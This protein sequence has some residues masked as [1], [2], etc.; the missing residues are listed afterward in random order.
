MSEERFVRERI[1]GWT[2]LRALVTRAQQRGLRSLSG[3]DVRRLGALYRAATADLATARTLR[4]DPDTIA[5]VNRVAAAAHDLVYAAPARPAGSRLWHFVSAGF[6]ALVRR[7]AAYHVTAGVTFLLGVAAAFAVFRH[8][9]AF[10]D[11]VFGPDLRARAVASASG[12]SYLELPGMVRPVFSWGI[13]TNN[14]NAMLAAFALATPFAFGG[15]VMMLYQGMFALG[16]VL[17]V[18][19]DEGAAGSV[20]TFAAA[21]GPLELTAIFIGC[22]AGMRIGVAP[23]L[24]GRRERLAA[25]V[26]TAKESIALVGGAALMLLLAAQFEGHVSPTTLPPVVKW[27]VGAV[28]V[29]LL[30][31]Y[32]GRAGRRT[33]ASS[34]AAPNR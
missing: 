18:F 1:E 19:A 7:T 8:D 10:A 3:A 9:P 33:A 25:F 13:V 6:P 22:G 34:D 28:W 12:A 4:L 16:G 23:L 31:L 11:T 17:A 14:V 29:V 26:D 27:S 24:P 32:F 15:V 30:A 20:L 21:H 2:D 5:H